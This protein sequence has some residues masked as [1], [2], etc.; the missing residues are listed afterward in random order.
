MSPLAAKLI[1]LALIIS[2]SRATKASSFVEG[3]PGSIQTDND[4]LDSNVSLPT[5]EPIPGSKVIR[6]HG[7]ILIYYNSRKIVY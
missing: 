3:F 1:T 7:K 2:C 5:F 6:M 4:V